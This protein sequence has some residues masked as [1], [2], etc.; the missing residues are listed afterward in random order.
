MMDSTQ[1]K[2]NKLEQ[3]ATMNIGR[4]L[5]NYSLPA[6]VGML[7]MQL[8]NF[9]DRSL[10]GHYGGVDGAASQEAIAGLTITFP[11]MNITTALGVLIGAGSA[12]RLSLLL[13]NGNIKGARDVLGNALT[14]T[15]IL[16]AIYLLAFAWFMDDMLLLFGATE[17]NLPYAREFM[18]YILPG[19]FLMNLT[20]S[21]NNLMRASGFPIR[22]MVT[23]FIGAGLNIILVTLFLVVFKMGIKGAAIASDIS[24]AVTTIFVMAHFFK[25]SGPIVW[26]RGTFTLQSSIVWGII[27]IGA[28]PCIVNVAACLINI[29]INSNLNEL[30]AVSSI[31]ADGALASAGVFVTFTMMIVS[32]IIGI[33]QGLQPIVG[34]N[35][36]AGNYNRLKR[37]YWL[38]V[39]ASTVMCLLGWAIA[40]LTPETI[41]KLIIPDDTLASH[42]GRMLRIAMS[43]FWVVGFQIVSTTFLQSIGKVSF[44]ILLSLARQVIFLLPIMYFLVNNFQLDGLWASFPT[45]DICATLVTMV[46]IIIEFR[47]INKLRG[48][49]TTNVNTL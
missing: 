44:S 43:M 42:T 33:C 45:S 38:A 46:L 17:T 32:V 41:V 14:M 25:N 22:A 24:M 37:A 35:Y 23:M 3:L 4:L 16:G 8:Y 19:L 1:L 11:V 7:V 9:V 10:I 13:G 26:T 20:F 40:M 48:I 34:Y 15:V 47:H 49:S 39:G 5:W 28:A 12:A 6:V 30:G 29:F 36:G 27:G 18:T 31:G 2:D 21:F